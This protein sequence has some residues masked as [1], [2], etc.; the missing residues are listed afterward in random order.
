M[1]KINV[2]D[3]FSGCG[4][5]S[6]GF[7]QAGMNIAFGLDN[8]KD[9]ANSFKANFPKAIFINDDI[10]TF[11]RDKLDDVIS[12]IQGATL[13]CGCAPCQPFSKQNRSKDK[14]DPRRGLLKEFGSLIANYLPTYIFVENVPG[15]QKPSIDTGP[16][17]GF[18]RKIKKLGYYYDFAVLPALLFG[19]PQTRARLVFI[20]SRNSEIELPKP[21]HGRKGIPFSTVSD[22]ISDLPALTAGAYHPGDL[23]H[24]AAEL[25][26]I[27][28]RRIKATPEGGGRQDWPE[29]LLLQCHKR[30]NGHTDVYGRLSWNKPA[31]GLTT[32]CISYS[33]GRFGHPE[34]DRAISAREAAC[35][36]TFPRNYRFRGSLNSIA[37]Q[38]GNAVPPLMIK[39]IGLTIKRH[40]QN[41]QKGPPHLCG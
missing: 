8:D 18:V 1:K 6:L 23:V 19:V 31:A 15:M 5:T 12:S 38:I 16:F 20:A 10:K 40:Y 4:G 21:T 37:R 25:S 28:L 30:H 3:F 29:D 13:F 33:N 34:Q 39:R 26:E 35:L 27:N 41:E 9:A 32:R 17:V 22:W 7:K 24:R 14:A 11:S 36:Q 2:F